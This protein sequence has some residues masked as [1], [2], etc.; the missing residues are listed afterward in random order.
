MAKKY[1]IIWLY[2]KNDEYKLSKDF[3]Y[4]KVISI[5]VWNCFDKGK[6]GFDDKKK[7]MW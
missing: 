7:I 6:A 5:D 2:S 1:K 3:L 4:I